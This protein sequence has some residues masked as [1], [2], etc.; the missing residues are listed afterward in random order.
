MDFPAGVTVGLSEWIREMVEDAVEVGVKATLGP[1]GEA[2]V[3]S[4]RSKHKDDGVSANG[5]CTTG[6]RACI[7][8][9]AKRLGSDLNYL[10]LW[11]Q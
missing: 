8:S 2:A 5:L 9:C 4:Q 7:G 1:V 3:N 11:H 10:Y 6:T